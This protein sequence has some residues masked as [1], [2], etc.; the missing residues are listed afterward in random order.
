MTLRLP[1]RIVP[2]AESFGI[3]D[4]LGVNVSWVYFATT[5]ERQQ[6]TRRVSKEEALR[7]AQITA[8]AVTDAVERE[9]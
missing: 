2:H 3:V 1:L 6:Q 5:P 7:I 8:R 4:A 9:G